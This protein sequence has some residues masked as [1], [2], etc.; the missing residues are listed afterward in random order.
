VSEVLVK[1]SLGITTPRW[2][3]NIRFDVTEI[4]WECVCVDL[5]NL[6]QTFV[7]RV[8]NILLSLHNEFP[9]SFSIRN[10]PHAFSCIKS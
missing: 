1:R 7:N 8:M 4:A 2:K 5:T 9:A 10:P 6:A 3:D